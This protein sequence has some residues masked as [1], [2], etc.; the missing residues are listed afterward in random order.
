MAIKGICHW[1]LTNNIEIP[2]ISILTL[3][4]QKK[5]KDKEKLSVAKPSKTKSHKLLVIINKVL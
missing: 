3:F 4:I 5:L 2:N 1:I